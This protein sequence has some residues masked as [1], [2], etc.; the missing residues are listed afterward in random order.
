M[1]ESGII[2]PDLL[3][4]CLTLNLGQEPLGELHPSVERYLF[5]TGRVSNEENFD[6]C[7]KDEAWF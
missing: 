6:F 2:A 7:R 5:Y 1:T 3:R 4:V